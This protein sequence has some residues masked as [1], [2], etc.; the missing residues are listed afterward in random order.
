MIVIS[1]G[2]SLNLQDGAY[3]LYRPYFYLTARKGFM[4]SYRTIKQE[5]SAEFVERRSKFIGH[6]KPVQTEDDAITFIQKIKTKHWDATHNVYAYSLKTGQTRRYSDDGEPQG[7]AGIPTLDVLLK[8]EVTDAVVVVTRYFGGIMLGAGGLVRAYSHAASLAI[9]ASGILQMQQ[10]H[11]IQI[12]CNYNQ[13]GKVSSLILEY[14]GQIDDTSFGEHVS[15]QFHMSYE[16]FNG[17][18]KQLADVTCGTVTSVVIGKD[19]FAVST[20]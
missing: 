9:E 15:V 6:I 16:N 12:S 2:L 1:F 20:L 18:E 5:I 8:A 4:E 14:N 13:Y 10:C 19:F 11:L 7:T 3:C 17:F